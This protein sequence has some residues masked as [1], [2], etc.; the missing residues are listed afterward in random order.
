MLQQSL[1]GEPVLNIFDRGTCGCQVLLKQRAEFLDS[2]SPAVPETN[3]GRGAQCQAKEIY[4]SSSMLL[5]VR[6]GATFV[7]S[8]RS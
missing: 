2:A 8:D 4:T 7:A 3:N 5:V 1:P 6:P